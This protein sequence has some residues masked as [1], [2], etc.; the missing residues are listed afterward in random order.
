MA[1]ICPLEGT[2]PFI[3]SPRFRLDVKT[4]K[5]L[6][7]I[8]LIGSMLTLSRGVPSG[9]AVGKRRRRASEAAME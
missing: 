5:P 7:L 2:E 4:A 9:N 6:Y 3:N 8:T 1:N